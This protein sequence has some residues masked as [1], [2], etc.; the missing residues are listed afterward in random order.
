MMNAG[1]LLAVENLPTSFCFSILSLDEPFFFGKTFFMSYFLSAMGV[2]HAEV[3]KRKT[4][5]WFLILLV[6]WFGFG[7]PNQ[8]AIMSTDSQLVPVLQLQR[9]TPPHSLAKK[10]SKPHGP[11]D[12]THHVHPFCSRLGWKKPPKK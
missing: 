8:H 10:T 1:I 6:D 5:T 12:M 7:W 2:T 9:Y 11:L 4:E 3:P